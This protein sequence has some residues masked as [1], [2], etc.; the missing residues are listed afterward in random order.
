MIP[1]ED[2]LIAVLEWVNNEGGIEA[3]IRVPRLYE[4]LGFADKFNNANVQ[5]EV[6]TLITLCENRSGQ[7]KM[8]E[9]IEHMRKIDALKLENLSEQYLKV[10]ETWAVYEKAPEEEKR[11]AEFVNNLVVDLSVLASAN[12]DN[13]LLFNKLKSIQLSIRIQFKP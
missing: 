9:L 4:E 12:K 10:L 7:G 8:A 3:D 11:F 6:R 13:F 5:T 2:L 1:K